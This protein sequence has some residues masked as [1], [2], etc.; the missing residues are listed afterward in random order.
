VPI[1]NKRKSQER[2]RPGEIR[3]AIVAALANK[4]LGASVAEIQGAVQ[5][6]IGDAA[7]SSVRSY[8]RLNSDSLF[9]RRGRGLY[10]IRESAE[11]YGQNGGKRL[12]FK[13]HTFARATLLEGDCFDWLRQQTSEFHPRGCDRPALWLG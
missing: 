3:D 11:T 1:A 6:L 12:S 4:P 7:S 10:T 2:R 9:H 8:L 13:S 5:Q